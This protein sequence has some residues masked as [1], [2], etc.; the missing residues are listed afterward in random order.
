MKPSARHYYSPSQTS[1]ACPAMAVLNR[2]YRGNRALPMQCRRAVAARHLDPPSKAMSFEYVRGIRGVQHFEVIHIYLCRSPPWATTTPE[3]YPRLQVFQG[4]HSDTHCH[5]LYPG[6][7]LVLDMLLRTNQKML[8]ARSRP[9]RRGTHT[10]PVPSWRG[11]VVMVQHDILQYTSKYM[12]KDP[13]P[14]PC[15]EWVG[16]EHLKQEVL[17]VLTRSNASFL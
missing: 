2:L 3:V 9:R 16:L 11:D 7:T 10:V 1:P 13:V 15:T 12:V 6:M 14:V 4:I 8:N 5:R 17:E